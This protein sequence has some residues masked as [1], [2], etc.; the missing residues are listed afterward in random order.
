MI[1]G[2]WTLHNV[3]HTSLLANDNAKA[4]PSNRSRID[5][6]C[7]V[8]VVKLVFILRSVLYGHIQTLLPGCHG[9]KELYS[10][11]YLYLLP[12]RALRFNEA[13]TT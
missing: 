5:V 12:A 6:H 4:I 9:N 2:Q 1:L 13:R 11:P 3:K 7:V 8:H 10:T